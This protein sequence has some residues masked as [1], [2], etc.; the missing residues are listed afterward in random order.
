VRAGNGGWAIGGDRL[1]AK[2]AKALRRRV[3]P[4]PKGRPPKR[5]RDRRLDKLTLSAPG[6]RQGKAGESPAQ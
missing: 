2:I 3:A 5:Q 1:K 4:L 6:D